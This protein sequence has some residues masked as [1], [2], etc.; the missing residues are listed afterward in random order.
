MPAISINKLAERQNWICQYCERR[1]TLRPPHLPARGTDATR[2]HRI[3]KSRGG[4]PSNG[5]LIA[6]CADC[7]QLKGDFTEWEF[8]NAILACIDAN[9]PIKR[10][11]VGGGYTPL[12]HVLAATENLP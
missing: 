5:N 3:P 12:R 6:S 10:N 11:V 4:G 9:M 2:E 7:N 8:A 1:M